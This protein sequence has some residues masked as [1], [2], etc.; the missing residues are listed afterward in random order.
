MHGGGR[1]QIMKRRLLIKKR[2]IRQR[3]LGLREMLAK[4]FPVVCIPCRSPRKFENYVERY[5]SDGSNF[6]KPSAAS[7]AL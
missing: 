4:E 7:A 5:S 6:S 3:K 2:L 1:Q